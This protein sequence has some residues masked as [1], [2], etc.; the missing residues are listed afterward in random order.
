MNDMAEVMFEDMYSN[1][2]SSSDGNSERK[3]ELMKKGRQ[4]E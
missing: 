1:G 2:K 4:E 3:N